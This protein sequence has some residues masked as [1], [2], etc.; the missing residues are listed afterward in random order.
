VRSLSVLPRFGFSANPSDVAETVDAALQAEA[1]GFDRIGVWDSPALYREPWVTLAAVAAATRRIRLGTW[2]TNPLTRHPVV[3]AGAAA[4]LDDLA[5]GRVVLGIGTGDTGVYGLGGTAAT[6]ERLAEYVT[7]LRSLLRDG[8]AVWQGN[9]VTLPWAGRR[10]VRILVAAHGAK[11]IRVAARVG[12]GAVLGLGVSPDVVERCRAE[13]SDAATA[14]G[15]DLDGF[16][17]WWTAPWYVADDGEAARREALWHV[18]S[19]AHHVSRRGVAGKFVPERYAAGILELGARYD[20]ATHGA[21]TRAQ[22]DEYAALAHRLGVADYLVDRFTIAG[23]PAEAADRVRHLAAAGADRLDC[24][25]DS[26]PGH[27]L[28]RPRTWAASVVP[29]LN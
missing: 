24:A 7:T 11:A 28:D 1:L 15:R 3:T 20:L 29:L 10:D 19:L 5:P 22:R 12:D 14:A 25:N 9:R 23:T 27:L 18:A 6:L 16:E 26:E 4:T 8:H 13:L 21:P 2:V 17:T